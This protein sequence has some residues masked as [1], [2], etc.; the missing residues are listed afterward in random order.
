MFIKQG[1]TRGL[2]DGFLHLNNFAHSTKSG[3][4]GAL[5]ERVFTKRQQETFIK[6]LVELATQEIKAMPNETFV[7]LYH[8]KH[9]AYRFHK[10]FLIKHFKGMIY[11]YL[12]LVR[13]SGSNMAAM[14]VTREVIDLYQSNSIPKVRFK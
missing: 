5:Y 3:I 9:G 1:G 4:A 14:A 13:A 11:G 12:K 2:P 8:I 6:L 7:Q 10:D